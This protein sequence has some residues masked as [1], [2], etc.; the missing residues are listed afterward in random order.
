MGRKKRPFYRIVVVDVNAP[1]DGQV[2]GELGTYDPIHARF[3]VDEESAVRWLNDGAQM[4]ETVHDLFKNQ[5]ILARW[6]GFDGKIREGALL[7]DKPK[8]RKKLAVVPAPADAESEAEEGT[9]APAEAT[10]EAPTT[11][12]E[13]QATSPPQDSEAEETPPENAA[14]DDGGAGEDAAADD[15]SENE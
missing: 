11:E 9:A 5:G 13:G 15:A 4:T 12:S 6:R 14:T 1:R 10:A 2:L 3:S 8:R 7:R